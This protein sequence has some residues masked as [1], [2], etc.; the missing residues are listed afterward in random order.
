MRI[1][2]YQTKNPMHMHR[3]FGLCKGD[4]KDIFLSFL[5]GLEPVCLIYKFV[6]RYNKKF[7][8]KYFKYVCIIQ[9]IVI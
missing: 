2:C 8:T 1:F 6:F 4:K 9:K 5:Y 3:V 7:L